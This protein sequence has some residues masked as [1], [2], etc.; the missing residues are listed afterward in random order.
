VISTCRGCLF[1]LR[2]CECSLKAI[3]SDAAKLAAVD[4]LGELDDPSGPFFGLAGT[5]DVAHSSS[6]NRSA[7]E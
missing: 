5:A 2:H 1:C 6:R 4:P 7:G 3:R